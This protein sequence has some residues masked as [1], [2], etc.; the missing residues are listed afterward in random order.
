[1]FNLWVWLLDMNHSRTLE[2]RH[3]VK[4]DYAPPPTH[5]ATPPPQAKAKR[6]ETKRVQ[7]TA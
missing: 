7:G 2:K 3:F 1:M 6:T 4:M 5:P